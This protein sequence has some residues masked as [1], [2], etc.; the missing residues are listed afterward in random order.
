MSMARRLATATTG[1]VALATA[2]GATYAVYA[3]STST[4]AAFRDRATPS[5]VA[6][7]P[8]PTVLG[9][10][11]ARPRVRI[12]PTPTV[13]AKPA[14]EPVLA[15]GDTGVKVRVLQGRL[16]QLAW[17]TPP[18][19]GRYTAPTTPVSYTHLTLPTILLV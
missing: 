11:T 15:P 9:T 1:L 13:T 7:Q 2:G 3:L 17:Y 4:D 19:T 16:S 8:S 14:P 6:A 18:M 12:A 10:Q 5:P